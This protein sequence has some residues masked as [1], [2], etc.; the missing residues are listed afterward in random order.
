MFHKGTRLNKKEKSKT[1]LKK[2]G[3][4]ISSFE[5]WFLDLLH[6]YELRMNGLKVPFS[7]IM[8]LPRGTF[9]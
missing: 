4:Y 2:V 1:H 6:F 5:K 9:N 7:Q 3:S 8:S